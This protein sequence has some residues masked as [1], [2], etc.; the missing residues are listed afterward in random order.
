MSTAAVILAAGNARRFGS[1]KQRAAL[2]DRTMLEV[3]CDAAVR[4]GLEPVIAVIPSDIPTPPGVTRVVNDRPNDGLS[5]SLR[6]GIAAVP[7][8]AEAAVILLGDQPTVA[9]A[10]IRA[11][12]RTDR[13]GRPVVASLIG[14]GAGPP[15]LLERRAFELVDRTAGDEGLRGILAT[16]TEL[17]TPFLPDEEP[18]D[19]D[20]PGDVVRLIEVCPGCGAVYRARADV[21][22]HPYIGASP[23]CWATYGA[24]LAR[25]FRDRAH[26]AVHRHA[27]D[28]YAAQHPGVDGRRQRQSV[29][30]HL[31]GLCGWL[32][33]RMNADALLPMTRRLTD[34]A[35]EW[36]WL[37]PP[38][39]YKVTVL[40]V[41]AAR[42][43]DEHVRL[44]RAW[45]EDVW[46]AWG[47]HHDLVRR[48]T[49]AALGS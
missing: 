29:A 17:V 7:E 31:I 14:D 19:V 13:E 36:P 18:V 37:D 9:P 32:E 26:G 10:T 48:W 46:S 41:L 33:H 21:E 27:V 39:G 1:P 44:V 47:A 38:K 22:T 30:V 20:T 12:L 23:A 6:M 5:A 28:A 11:L 40:D 42:S 45:A 8:G 15:L 49:D 43:G 16:H 2:G 25:E 34:G 4:A 35:R 24:V 3:V